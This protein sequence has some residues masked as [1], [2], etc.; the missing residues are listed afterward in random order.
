MA[1]ATESKRDLTHLLSKQK[2][3]K[4]ARQKGRWRS[5]MKRAVLVTGAVTAVGGLGALGYMAFGGFFSGVLPTQAVNWK[6]YIRGIEHEPHATLPLARLATEAE[7]A[8]RATP[9][10]RLDAI[11]K[12]IQAR[13]HA[14]QVTVARQSGDELQIVLNFREPVMRVAADRT[15][16]LDKDGEVYTEPFQNSQE[17][18][19]LLS[20]LFAEGYH[21]EWTPGGALK[22]TEDQQR[23]VGEAI[24]L[25]QNI[26]DK[27]LSFSE[28][29]HVKFRGFTVVDQNKHLEILLGQAPYDKKLDRLQALLQ[30]V[31]QKGQTISRI[32]L[33]YEGKAFIKEKTF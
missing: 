20:G 15:R 11:A 4:T 9:G 33:D 30:Q 26:Q 10:R 13:L 29:R 23:I 32:E 7:M 2:P 3:T 16:L 19:P 25:Q 22:L 18:L 27:K 21:P 17:Q 31:Q 28:L 6:V 12:N 8:A 5:A 14:K 24:A 1:K